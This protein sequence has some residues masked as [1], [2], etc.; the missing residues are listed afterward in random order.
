MEL[1]GLVPIIWVD[2]LK[3]TLEF[4][5]T[6]LG[7]TCEKI[8][9]NNSWASI[10]RDNV[11]FI[12]ALPNEHIEFTKPIFTGSFYILTDNVDNIWKQL[13]GKVSI[14]YPIED[15]DYGMRE[16]AIYDNNSY[17][18]QFGQEIKG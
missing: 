2:N 9:D 5:T 7:F 3:A 13:N 8:S 18:I 15:F 12:I 4:Y 16:F 11:S 6:K 14:A 10:F 1:T 17:M